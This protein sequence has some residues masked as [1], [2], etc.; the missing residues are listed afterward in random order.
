MDAAVAIVPLE[1]KLPAESRSV[2]RARQAVR[3]YLESLDVPDT[4]GVELAVSEAVGNAV[5]HAYT[6]T[7]PGTIELRASVLVP[8]TLVVDV[9]DDG[10]GMAPRADSPG[11][12]FGLPL[13]GEVSDSFAVE[14]NRPHGTRVAM[15]FALAPGDHN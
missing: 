6:D 1:R 9:C 2:G 12:G 5:V 8:D 3:G 15:R 4:G 11:L 10:D 7:P 13:I 14:Q